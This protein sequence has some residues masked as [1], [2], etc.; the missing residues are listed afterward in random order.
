MAF[1]DFVSN[2][3]TFDSEGKEVSRRRGKSRKLDPN[4][5]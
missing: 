2:R 4:N 3:K 1:P 5:L